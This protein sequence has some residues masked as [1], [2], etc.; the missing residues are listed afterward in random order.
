MVY[1]HHLPKGII[2]SFE[3]NPSFKIRNREIFYKYQ[4]AYFKLYVREVEIL[5]SSKPEEYNDIKDHIFI[6][7]KQYHSRITRINDFYSEEVKAENLD[8]QT[9][10]FLE[11][12][13]RDS[14][15]I[16]CKDKY[17]DIVWNC[18]YK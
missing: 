3:E 9:K 5:I 6:F 1:I 10:A 8:E 2:L 13:G 14:C 15:V 7:N 17:L 12:N 18:N 4:D 11:E 16:Q